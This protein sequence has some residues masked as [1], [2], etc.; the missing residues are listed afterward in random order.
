[1]ATGKSKST[2]TS[3]S[4]KPA[5]KFDQDKLLQTIQSLQFVWF[6]GNVLTLIGF[7][8]YSLTYLKFIPSLYKPTYILTL[9]GIFISF[10]IL[11]FQI[12]Q[13]NG[14]KLPILIKDDNFHYILLAGFLL[15]LRPY[16]L[17]TLVP[18]VIFATFHVLA[19]INGFLLPIFGLNNSIISKYITNFI[20]NNN[21]KSIQIASGIELITFVWLILR[22]LLFRKRSLSP[23]LVYLIFLKKRHE[24]SPFTRNY[25][26]WIGNTIDGFVIDIGQPVLTQVWGHVKTFFHTVDQYK[27]VH[28]WQAE[29]AAKAK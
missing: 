7:L 22:M 27:L 9:I 26:N 12:I 20:S 21:A 28:D 24:V 11:I 13:K 2:A 6:L 16:V 4:S 29:E 18:F 19:Y 15:F 3:A 5:F 10:G 8:F 17:L 25:L 23:V 14:F 1:M